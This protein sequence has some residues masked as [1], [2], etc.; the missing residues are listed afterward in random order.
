MRE[1][2]KGHQGALRE[3]RYL[4]RE[5]IKANQGALREDRYL[6]REDIKGHQG[7]LRGLLVIISGVHRH[8]D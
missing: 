6:M 5:V 4:M 1:V 2:I 3:D 8:S 7:A